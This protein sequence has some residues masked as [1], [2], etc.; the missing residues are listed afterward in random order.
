[1]K[2]RSKARIDNP[3]DIS[4]STSRSALAVNPYAQNRYLATGKARHH[5]HGAVAMEFAWLFTLVLFPLL[6]CIIAFGLTFLVRESMQYSVEEAAR[7][8]LRVPPPSIL[9]GARQVTWEHRETWARQVLGNA[10]LW[11]PGNLRPD[12]NNVHFTACSMQ[13]ASCTNPQTSTDLPALN[14]TLQCSIDAPCLIRLR[15]DIE[16][17]PSHAIAPPL[18]G[19]GV[20][21]PQV[22]SAE[23]QILLTRTLL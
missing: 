6:Y 1:M 11:A 15:F 5:Q 13:Q 9:Q 22:L 21:Y 23:A 8:S 19:L 18:P 2:R 14:P 12:Q 3:T 16:D 7:E 10:M 20:I 17:Y 4:T